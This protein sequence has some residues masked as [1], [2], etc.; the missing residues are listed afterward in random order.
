MVIKVFQKEQKIKDY[1]GCLVMNVFT[2]VIF[3]Y[4]ILT[5]IATTT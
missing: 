3:N 4:Y 2:L 5:T 1:D